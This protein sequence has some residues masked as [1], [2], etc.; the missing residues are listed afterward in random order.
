MVTSTAQHYNPLIA[1]RL[2]LGMTQETLALRIGIS[3]N[4][5][6]RC[7]QGQF[8]DLV[9]SVLDWFSDN[10]DDFDLDD[11]R[12]EYREFQHNVRS[13]FAGYISYANSAPRVTHPGNVLL[14]QY[15]EGRGITIPGFCRNFCIHQAK[16]YDWITRPDKYN[17]VPAIVITALRDAGIGEMLIQNVITDYKIYHENYR[18]RFKV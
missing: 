3:R 7:E 17:E 16:M 12:H 13:D 9:P 4:V 10:Y 11:W 6:I 14:A 8:P 15:D 18:L 5:L 2:K 1:A